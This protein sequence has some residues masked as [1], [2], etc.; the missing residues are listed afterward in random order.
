MLKIGEFIYPWGSGHYS[1]M[2]RL[3]EVL[4]EHIK[5]EF[6][7]H[8]SS[9]DHVYEKL[10]KKFPEQK[11]KI[12]E[13]L[14]PTPIDGKFGP[15]VSM[16]LMNL[17]L[18]ISKNPPLVRQIANYLREERK[19]YNKEKFD[20]VINDGD[21]GSNILARNRNIPSLFVTNQFRPK[22][23]NSRAYLYPSLIFVAKQIAKA[24]KI[25][26][27]DS[28]PPYTMCEYNLNFIKEVEEKITYVGHFTNS[29]KI[30]KEKES[31]LEKLV[32]DGEFGY[33]MRTGN[34]STNDGTG[35]RYEGV[36]H[37]NEMKNEKRIISH[38][39]NDPNIDSVIGKDGGKYSITEA[40]EKK[41]DWIQIDIGFLSEQEK[42]TVLDLCKYAVVNGSHTVMGEIMGGKSKPIIGI[43]IYDEHTN[44]IK[45]AEEKNLGILAIKTDQV[46]KGISKIKENYETFQDSLKEFSKNFVPNG[47]EN[48]AKIAAQTLEEKR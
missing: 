27:A 46:T 17:L 38:A 25:L 29:K 18:P 45:W 32:K 15:S 44:N 41:I 20:L 16:S 47:A 23:Y 28:P 1:R 39:R 22:L 48:S 34:K 9:K 2:M 30:K 37:Q 31:D 21:M 7:V 3:N 12:H 14:M 24:S 36:F 11:E 43:P 19:L 42:D 10:L 13:I 26:V 35:Q 5:E 8:F 40:F 4:G 6:E 33:W